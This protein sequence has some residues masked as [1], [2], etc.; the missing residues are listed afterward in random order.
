MA[1]VGQYLRYSKVFDEQANLRVLA[2]AATLDATR[3]SGV[4]EI[5]PGYGSVYVEWEDRTLS[6]ERATAWID[7]A[8]EAD[9]DDLKEPADITVPVSYG[10]LDTDEVAEAD[11]P[12]P[13]R[14]RRGARGQE[15]PRLRPRDGRP[16]DDGEHRR[17]PARPPARRPAHRRPRARRR[18]RQR[19]GHDLPGADAGRVERDRHR[20]RERLR[21]AP[22]RP[23]PVRAGRH[24]PLRARGR[25]GPRRPPSAASCCP[26]RHTRPRCASRRPA[27]STSCSTAAASTRRITGWRRPARSTPAPPAWPT[28]SAATR[29]A[30]R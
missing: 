14:D 8:L 13:R 18:D 22:R 24:G 25:R 29:P 4:R 10:G 1:P 3:P 26:R 27:R 28:G 30:R 12:E 6:N 19:A 15:L 23:V 7:A 5:Y 20:A 16:A 2:L 11:R 9:H 21:P 17:A